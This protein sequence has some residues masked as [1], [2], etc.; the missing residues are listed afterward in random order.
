[1]AFNIT[2][3]DEENVAWGSNLY[4][5][6]DDL[7]HF[8]PI[9]AKERM[10]R[11]HKH[12]G[13]RHVFINSRGNCMPRVLSHQLFTRLRHHR[14]V[15]TTS[16]HQKIRGAVVSQLRRL[17]NQYRFGKTDDEY[18]AYSPLCL[19]SIL[20]F[21]LKGSLCGLHSGMV[22]EDLYADCILEWLRRYIYKYEKL[23]CAVTSYLF[24]SV[25]NL[26]I[27]STMLIFY[28]VF[29]FERISMRT[30]FWNA[31]LCLS[32]IL[33]FLLKGSLCGLH[34]GM[35]E[36]VDLQVRETAVCCDFL[37]LCDNKTFGIS[38]ATILLHKTFGISA[39]SISATSS[40]SIAYRIVSFDLPNYIYW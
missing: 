16:K 23:L 12:Y 37:F 17:P 20:S 13:L 24:T 36:E 27:S 5:D 25:F 31:P 30:A 14:R 35:V 38:A 6:Y 29:S 28:F 33:S 4:Q 9:G 7:D 32:S 40:M 22:E 2:A 15:R 19:S 11:R 26:F 39:T 34:S 3:E 8:E 10:R 18:E 1:M 21:L